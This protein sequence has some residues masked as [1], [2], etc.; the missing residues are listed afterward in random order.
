MKAITSSSNNSSR[1]TT[2]TEF[3][4]RGSYDLDLPPTSLEGIRRK[5]MLTLH[6]VNRETTKFGD[7][8]LK[9][10]RPL[11]PANWMTILYT[12]SRRTGIR[13]DSLH[14]F[15]DLEPLLDK[16]KYDYDLAGTPEYR[17]LRE[18]CDRG[19]A[20]DYLA[21]NVRNELEAAH[22]NYLR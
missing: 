22:L 17:E 2:V 20:F 18:I 8:F 3:N 15:K 19:R 1:K 7:Y 21:F 13:T 6:V 16:L 9:N 14:D 4:L 10:I 12:I 11:D 5:V